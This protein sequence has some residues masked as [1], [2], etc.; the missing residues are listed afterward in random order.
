M[1]CQLVGL[2]SNKKTAWTK[3]SFFILR[4]LWK[5]YEE[6]TQGGNVENEQAFGLSKLF[7][8]FYKKYASGNEN[9]KEKFDNWFNKFDVR[10]NV[11]VNNQNQTQF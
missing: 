10:Y 11:A 1:L 3:R 4:F 9:A 5:T 8:V 7:G 2:I 6:F